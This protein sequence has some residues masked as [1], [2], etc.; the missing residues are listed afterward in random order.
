[1]N[2]N[3]TELISIVE[4][5]KEE[6]TETPTTSDVDVTKASDVFVISTGTMDAQPSCS[7]YV[8]IKKSA[9]SD[10]K[11][12]KFLC[13]ICGR[14][15]QTK[16]SLNIHTSVHD[17]KTKHT[18]EAEKE[19]KKNDKIKI[20]RINEP[21]KVKKKHNI[22]E[23]SSCEPKFKCDQC[24]ESFTK[25]VLLKV[26]KISHS[27]P[28]CFACNFCSKT[29]KTMEYLA[30]HKKNHL[31][32]EKCSKMFLTEIRYIRHKKTHNKK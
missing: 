21:V 31:K 25:H 3:P 12:F 32:C 6:I 23:A 30:E 2:E 11:I 10:H 18:F 16:T 15:F 1:M 22:A 9:S 19:K 29:F 14:K 7:N 13:D 17:Y 26:H 27:H 4:I 8:Q 28:K 20:K 24:E 5:K